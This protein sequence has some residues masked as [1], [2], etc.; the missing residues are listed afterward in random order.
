MTLPL[1]HWP[2]QENQY[3][4]CVLR[5]V[6]VL[7]YYIIIKSLEMDTHR[8]LVDLQSSIIAGINELHKVDTYPE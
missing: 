3:S 8:V 4:K 6:W 5:V 1:E 2:S 7:Y